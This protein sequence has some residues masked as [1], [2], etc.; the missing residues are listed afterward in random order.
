[1]PFPSI[2]QSALTTRH[3]QLMAGFSELEVAHQ[4]HAERAKESFEQLAQEAAAL[5]HRQA[6]YEALQVC[7]NRQLPAS[8]AQHVDMMP[9]A[10]CQSSCH[11]CHMT[12]S[13]ASCMYAL[14]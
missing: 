14:L 11:T 10:N 1:M 9:W 2:L 7:A 6:R 12:H 4:A 13:V 3:D 5:E 8:F